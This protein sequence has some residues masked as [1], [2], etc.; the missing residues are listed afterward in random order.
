MKSFR[1]KFDI[2]GELMAFLWH[3]K[4]WWLIPLIAVLVLFGLLLIFAGS[5]GIAPFIYPLI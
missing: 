3:R 4:L 5:S 1:S 2:F